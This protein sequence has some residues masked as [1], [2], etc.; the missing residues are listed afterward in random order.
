MVFLK[1]PV[2]EW[3]SVRDD[4]HQ[5][6]LQKFYADQE[7]YSFPFQMMS[8]V[9]RLALLKAAIKENPFAVIISERSLLTD[10][11]VFAK[12]LYE[13]KKME[14]VHYQIYNNL[15]R[16]FS[17]EFPIHQVVYLKTNPDICHQRI[18]KR[19]RPGED[20]IPMEYLKECHNYHEDMMSNGIEASVGRCVLDGNVDIFDQTSEEE[21]DKWTKQIVDLIAHRRPGF[22]KE[23]KSG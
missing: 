19:C 1:E 8:Y 7:R 22:L 20:S 21:V 18:L 10:K 5:S 23:Y 16:T 13:A 4:D 17:E 9:S 2:D 15:Y 6:M 14:S 11:Y 12:M 3:E